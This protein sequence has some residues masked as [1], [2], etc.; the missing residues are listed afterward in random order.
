MVKVRRSAALE[1]LG[2]R[3]ALGSRGPNLLSMDQLVERHDADEEETRCSCA[4][5]LRPS[6]ALLETGHG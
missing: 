2:S 1:V 4:E 5:S 6:P 3:S